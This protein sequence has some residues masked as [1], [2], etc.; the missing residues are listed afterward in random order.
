M[1]KK[2]NQH[3]FMPTFWS[4]V[5]DTIKAKRLLVQIFKATKDAFKGKEDKYKGVFTITSSSITCKSCYLNSQFFNSNPRIKNYPKT[6]E[7][8]YKCIGRLTAK[9]M[10]ISFKWI[11]SGLILPATQLPF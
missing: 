7:G 9:T 3:C 2:S 6:N 5:I 1:R 10:Q 11:V 4:N 8:L